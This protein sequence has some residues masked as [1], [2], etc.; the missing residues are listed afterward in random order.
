M[1]SNIFINPQNCFLGAIPKEGPKAI[2]QNLDWTTQSA[3]VFDMVLVAQ[4]GKLSGIQ[5]A[6][7]DN[8]NN[9][10][11]VSVLSSITNQTVTIA[12]GYQGYFPLLVSPQVKVTFSST[13]TKSTPIQLLN[14]PIAAS[15]WPGSVA[16]GTNTTPLA[17]V[18]IVD[19]S[20]SIAVGGVAQV[21]NGAD[22]TRIL[23]R[24]Q[25]I[26]GAEDLWYTDDGSVPTVGGQGSFL[27]TAGGF[28]QGNSQ[29]AITVIATTAGHKYTLK[30]Q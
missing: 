26:D 28:A 25:N 24:L 30:T 17:V 4:L 29:Q 1:Q 20:G 7:I 9:D 15:I 18:T 3:Y 19:A 23:Y 10:K 16:A 6:F 8:T 27:V 21:A 22:P 13:G 2:A 12:A 5:A 11:P 14:F